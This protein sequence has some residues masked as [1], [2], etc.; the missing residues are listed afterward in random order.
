[1]IHATITS[2]H[3][4]FTIKERP[5]GVYETY[6]KAVGVNLSRKEFGDDTLWIKLFLRGYGI[7]TATAPSFDSGRRHFGG[8]SE[9]FVW[10]EFTLKKKQKSPNYFIE[11]IDAKDD[12]LA[13][14]WGNPPIL[15]AF[16]FSNLVLKYLM[17]GQPDN[18]LL[19][20]LYWNMKLLTYRNIP[21]FAA[22]WRF[23]WSWL[24]EWGLAPEL[25][26]FHRHM[27]F[28]H[29]EIVLLTKL[30]RLNHE[31]VKQMFSM[32]LGLTIRENALKIAVKLAV[33]FLD[34][35]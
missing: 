3:K 11:D 31:G 6:I 12:M 29:D 34:E 8:D 27:K 17:P 26:D 15:A 35:K 5:F 21:V 1:M 18:P 7:L 23:V 13:I 19:N 25:V 2:I 16:R 33:Q 10:A 9:P 24:K 22:E 20:N 4:T 30:S 14:R 32:P 28:S